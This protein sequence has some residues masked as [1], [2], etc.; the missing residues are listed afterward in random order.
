MS[1]GDR[2]QLLLTQLYSGPDRQELFTAFRLL[3]IADSR[4]QELA[5]HQAITFETFLRTCMDR[6]GSTPPEAWHAVDSSLLENVEQVLDTVNHM[7]EG[8]L[9]TRGSVTQYWSRHADATASF[10]P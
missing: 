2:Y 7:V 4:L 8:E 10:T 9:L 6:L 1:P 3:G 5:E